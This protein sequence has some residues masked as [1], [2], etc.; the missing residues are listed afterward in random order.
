MEKIGRREEGVVK[1]EEE[2][3]RVKHRGG[4]EW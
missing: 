1:E 2:K 4:H 3:E